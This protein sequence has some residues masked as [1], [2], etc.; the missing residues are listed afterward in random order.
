MSGGL[1]PFREDFFSSKGRRV[2]LMPL[3]KVRR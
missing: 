2:G 1:G 3:L